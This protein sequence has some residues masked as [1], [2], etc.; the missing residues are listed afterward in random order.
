MHVATV[1]L[2]TQYDTFQ[3]CAACSKC[4]SLP[5]AVAGAH[6]YATRLVDFQLEVI[7]TLPLTLYL[8]HGTELRVVA[9]ANAAAAAD[10]AAA[11]SNEQS[12][13]VPQTAVLLVQVCTA[14]GD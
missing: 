8:I 4:T 1:S 2:P 5:S 13:A 9:D 11:L 3:A 14:V 6:P 10:A 7:A 12:A